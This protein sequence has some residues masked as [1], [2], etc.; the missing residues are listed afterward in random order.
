MVERQGG[1]GLHTASLCSS[2]S[3][4]TA[5][6][7]RACGSAVESTPLGP[8]AALGVEMDAR[9]RMCRTFRV[10]LRLLGQG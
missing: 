5:T 8:L 7:D 9:P 4:L 1:E 10:R 2:G 3:R 6:D